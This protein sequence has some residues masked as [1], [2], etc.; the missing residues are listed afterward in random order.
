MKFNLLALAALTTLVMAAC[1]P[2][3]EAAPVADAPAVA[4]PNNLAR[5]LATNQDVQP[6][7]ALIQRASI[8][9][10]SVGSTADLSMPDAVTRIWAPS[11]TDTLPDVPR[12]Q[13]SA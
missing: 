13:P 11:R 9:T 5:L 12:I 3:D 2:A 8:S 10:A 1:K 6:S 7:P 4:S